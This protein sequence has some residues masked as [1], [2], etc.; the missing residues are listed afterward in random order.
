M[1]NGKAEAF[2]VKPYRSLGIEHAYHGMNNFRHGVTRIKNL[3]VIIDRSIREVVVAH[4]YFEPSS[5]RV[6]FSSYC[7]AKIIGPRR[8]S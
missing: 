4:Y 3:Q 6:C 5:S 1:A 7:A 2:R 8:A